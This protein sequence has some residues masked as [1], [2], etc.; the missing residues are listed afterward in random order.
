MIIKKLLLTKRTIRELKKCG[1]TY[2]EL[3]KSFDCTVKTIW[4]WLNKTTINK[5][6][7]GRKNKINDNMCSEIV[8]Y[9]EKNVTVTQSDISEILLNKFNVSINQSNI[10]RFLYKNNISRKKISKNIQKKKI[11]L[12]GKRCLKM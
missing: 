6:K 4:N 10:S 8:N 3:S 11:F 12:Y 2:K 5:N 9:I 7:R 1:L